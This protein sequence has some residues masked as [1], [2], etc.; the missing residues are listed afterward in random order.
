MPGLVLCGLQ[1][2]HPA[3]S[4]PLLDPS[5]WARHKEGVEGSGKPRLGVPGGALPSASPSLA[6]SKAVPG[7]AGHGAQAGALRL[8]AA[9]VHRSPRIC[10]TAPAGLGPV[11]GSVAQVVLLRRGWGLQLQVLQLLVPLQQADPKPWIPPSQKFGSG[12]KG[13]SWPLLPSQAKL[14]SGSERRCEEPGAGSG[15]ECMACAPSAH[16]IGFP[17][18]A[19]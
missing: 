4:A 16:Q 2:Q 19:C 11:L 12:A 14:K 15:A 1:E 18:I 7:P 5:S 3:L 9:L 10:P 17:E 6:Q 13:D 8:V